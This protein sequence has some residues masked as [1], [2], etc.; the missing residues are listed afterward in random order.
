MNNPDHDILKWDLIRIQRNKLLRKTDIYVLPD[1]PHADDT[2]KNDWL[3]YRQK[4]RD[5]PSSI[6]ISTILFDEEGVLTG[7]NW[8]TQPS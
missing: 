3:T 8:P 2:I 1:F 7:I 5:F 4:L 6:D